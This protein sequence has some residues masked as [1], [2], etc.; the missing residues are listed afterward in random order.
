MPPCTCWRAALERRR[1][2]PTAVKA[3]LIKP[4]CHR[5]LRHTMRLAHQ[6]NLLRSPQA[7]KMFQARRRLPKNRCFMRIL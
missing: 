4:P 1:R 5:W 2:H 7:E 3:W 6:P